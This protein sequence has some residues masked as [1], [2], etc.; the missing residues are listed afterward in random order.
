MQVK[1]K[2]EIESLD[3]NDEIFIFKNLQ[4]ELLNNL[5]IRGIKNIKKFYLEKL[6][7]ILNYKILNILK[8]LWVLDTVGSNLIDILALD[9]VDKTRTTT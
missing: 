1:N 2:N 4:E 9:F 3:Q 8:K 7:I 6:L 5:T